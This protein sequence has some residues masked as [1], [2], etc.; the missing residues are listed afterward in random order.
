MSQ[1]ALL[2]RMFRLAG[3]V[4][5][6]RLG[7]MG[8]GVADTVIVGQLAPKELSHLALG[9]APTGVFLVGGIGLLAGVQVLTARMIGEG[10]RQHAGSVL[11][12]GLVLGWI[13]GVLASVI[14]ALGA[15]P[16][17]LALG[18]NPE[19]AAAAARVQKPWMLLKQWLKKEAI[20]M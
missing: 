10:R 19:L 4:A 5:I 11:R 6:A 1:D 12:R 3:P 15:H 13:A 14:I 20:L 17:L 18:I 2:A 16:A 9:W 8:M 7:I